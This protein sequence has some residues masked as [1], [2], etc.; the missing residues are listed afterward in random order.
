MSV[1]D[2]P[3]PY[4]RSFDGPAA[5]TSLDGKGA[6][7]QNGENFFELTCDHSSCTWSLMAQTLDVGRAGVV[8]MYQGNLF[9]KGC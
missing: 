2:I 8:M 7:L 1:P 6:F 3:S 4:Y 9:K 5:L